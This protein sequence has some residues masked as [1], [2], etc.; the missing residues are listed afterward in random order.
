MNDRR[1]ALVGMAVWLGMLVGVVAL[2]TAG[3]AYRSTIVLAIAVVLSIGLGRMCLKALAFSRNMQAFGHVNDRDD[4]G[5]SPLHYAAAEGDA[6]TVQLLL[7]NGADP[8]ARDAAGVTPLVMAHAT[9]T[10]AVVE[11]LRGRG[12]CQS[13]SDSDYLGR[14]PL[15]HAAAEG[16]V[17]RM[18]SLLAEGADPNARDSI[19]LTPLL[20]AVHSAN[21]E[22][23]ALLLQHGAKP[24]AQCL[25][26][27]QEQNRQDI[28]ALL[29]KSQ[30]A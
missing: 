29:R 19:G 14:T 2:W 8:N 20:G 24:D 17:G 27:A 18:R 12:A 11:L 9:G 4:K 28:L 22:A 25:E 15:H 30:P 1:E 21:A 16:D 5:R 10:S 6:D 3:I 26:W 23:V 13:A 7:A